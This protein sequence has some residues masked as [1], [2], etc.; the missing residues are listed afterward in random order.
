[1][2]DAG[3]GGGE[4]ASAER[5]GRPP[6]TEIDGLFTEFVD[7]LDGPGG[8]SAAKRDDL[9]D[10]AGAAHEELAERMRLYESL[11]CKQPSRL[12]RF[13]I[14]SKMGD[15]GLG[16][17]YLARDPQLKRQVAL[18]VLERGGNLGRLERE[19]MLNEARSLAKLE[20]PGVVKVFEVGEAD[21]VAFLVMEHL[22]GPSLAEVIDELRRRADGAPVEDEVLTPRQEQLARLAVRLAPIEARVACLAKLADALGYCHGRGV[23]H[24]DVKPGNILFDKDDE[25]RLIDFGLA[26]V[27]DSESGLD[28]T[29]RLIGSPGYVAPEQVEHGRTGDDPRSD[30]FV[31]GVV[32]Y[33]L[34]T[35][36]SPFERPTRSLTMDA[37]AEAR[38]PRLRS[39]LPGRAPA[40]LDR[41]VH[42]TL[43]QDP[44][45]RYPNVLAFAADLRAVLEH[46]PISVERPT[47]WRLGSLWLRRNRRRVALL[48]LTAA[49]FVVALFLIRLA[50]ERAERQELIESWHGWEPH[51]A[52]GPVD[53]IARGDRLRRFLASAQRFDEESTFASVLGPLTPVVNDETA[54]WSDRVREVAASAEFDSRDRVTTIQ[55]TTWRSLFDLEQALWPDRSD[56]EGYWRRGRVFFH[57]PADSRLTLLE[58]APLGRE[59]RLGIVSWY[60]RIDVVESL[61]PSFY[62]AVV[63]P[64][65]S[66]E[67][68]F[69]TELLLEDPWAEALDVRFVPLKESYR[70]TSVSFPRCPLNL[71]GVDV[72]LPAFLVGTELVTADELGKEAPT[73]RDALAF[74]ARV[75]GRLPSSHELRVAFTNGLEVPGD[76]HGEWVSDIRLNR[77]HFLPYN[78]ID[79]F[80]SGE[81]I[82]LCLQPAAVD[83][84]AGEP[85][86]PVRFRVARS[87]ELGF[88]ERN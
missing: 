23:L 34:F 21:G 65:D 11:L 37:I 25:P 22:S 12:G 36:K 7:A 56:A 31:L 4:R 45:D 87:L 16:R 10:R 38:P 80:L 42:H 48:A 28:I 27:I 18:K 20:H 26:H 47:A 43:E 46:R 82:S 72:L 13:E 57:H 79:R 83:A 1:M 59:K 77:P 75:G 81:D 69:E 30:Q 24:R 32:G 86:N 50:E 67:L 78:C 60:T 9:L 5:S 44:N 15:G 62:R 74:V 88:D 17:V 58:Q 52:R 70:D 73:F 71:E 63:T 55:S 51:E 41:I 2:T 39:Q 3:R 66:T 61:V 35:C 14:L 84:N 33:E 6:T 40:G 53:L 85:D 19:W 54:T 49:A 64:P 68:I 8:V 76:A 29:Q